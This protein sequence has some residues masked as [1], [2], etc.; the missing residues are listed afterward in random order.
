LFDRRIIPLLLIHRGGVY[1]TTRFGE[2]RYIGDPLNAISI[3]N[4]KRVDEIAVFDVDATS[5]GRG[6]NLDFVR[7]FASECFVPVCYGGGIGSIRDMHDVLS[8]GV[9]KVSVGS[10]QNECNLIS[11]GAK[12][13]GSQAIVVTLDVGLGPDGRPQV[14]TQRGRKPTG[15]DPVTA[16]RRVADLGAGEIVVQSIERD[17]TMLGYDRALICSVAKAVDVPVVAAGGAR[18][19]EDIAATLAETGASAAIAGSLFLYVGRLKGVLITFPEEK[20][21]HVAIATALQS[22]RI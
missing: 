21:R 12:V 14:F 9:E 3:F 22:A 5:E 2:P 7:D 6:P 17:G 19:L 10:A 15:M 20:E 18:D 1:K 8:I 4:E 16:A 11:D 13:F